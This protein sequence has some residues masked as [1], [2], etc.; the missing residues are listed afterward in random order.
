MCA[1]QIDPP[2]D[3]TI[4]QEAAEESEVRRKDPCNCKG[5]SKTE[6]YFHH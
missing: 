3:F 1:G 6:A 4:G 2:E 5:P